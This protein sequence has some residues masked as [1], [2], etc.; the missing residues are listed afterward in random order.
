MSQS[1]NEG[2]VGGTDLILLMRLRPQFGKLFPSTELAPHR[3]ARTRFQAE[4]DLGVLELLLRL[5]RESGQGQRARSISGPSRD[6]RGKGNH[7]LSVPLPTAT[8]TSVFS[9]TIGIS[10]TRTSLCDTFSATAPAA[11]PSST[12]MD[13]TVNVKK[14]LR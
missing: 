3:G 12:T 7:V 1:S 5:I 10:M 11:P 2:A 9:T 13:V 4:M 14:S 8:L 6:I